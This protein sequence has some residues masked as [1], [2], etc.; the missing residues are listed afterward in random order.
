M[1]VHKC[2][3]SISFYTFGDVRIMSQKTYIQ[4]QQL[5]S[6]M[7]NAEKRSS[8]KYVLRFEKEVLENQINF[9]IAN[10]LFGDAKKL[11]YVDFKQEIGLSSEK[12]LEK[13]L[14][15]L[16]NGIFDALISDINVRR[17]RRLPIQA[18]HRTDVKK[19]HQ[20]VMIAAGKGLG[21]IAKIYLHQ[22][23]NKA[24]KNE[25]YTDLV[26]ALYMKLD[27]IFLREKNKVFEGILKEIA[28]YEECMAAERKAEVLLMRWMQQVTFSQAKKD[29]NFILNAIRTTKSLAKKTKSKRVLFVAFQLQ[30]EYYQHAGNYSKSNFYC[31]KMLVLMRQHLFLHKKRNEGGVLMNMAYNSLWA[32]KLKECAQHLQM[33]TDFFVSNSFNS[34]IL[35]EVAFKLAYLQGDMPSAKKLA[36]ETLQLKGMQQ[37]AFRQSKWNYYLA[38]C[39]FMEKEYTQ[40]T[41]AL[42]NCTEL[43]S[44]KIG[45]Q[46]SIETLK[47]ASLIE[48]QL[49]DVASSEIDYL[50]RL[51]KNHRLRA[52]DKTALKVLQSMQ[53]EGFS[54]RKVYP[55]HKSSIAKLQKVQG[56]YQ[57]EMQTPELFLFDEWFM[58]K[59]EDRPYQASYKQFI[60]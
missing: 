14:N 32:G 7:D 15:N 31:K 39:C 55:I 38:C 53:E 23:I 26:E 59:L 24:K 20:K 29:E 44:D 35:K 8:L 18:V 34:F 52:R 48:R 47:I 11:N 16:Q 54:F 58:S 28:H 12:N 33:A 42:N 17:R 50:Q 27:T 9:R 57:Q 45:W 51:H 41:L 30:M 2:A 3:N 43:S 49:L 5:I 4:L 1:S 36:L 40:S 22:L 37:N 19:L 21:G 46:L 56:W 25:F 60:K 6:S 10:L 13:Y